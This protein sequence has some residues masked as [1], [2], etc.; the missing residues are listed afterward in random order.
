MPI[1]S[2]PG[3]PISWPR[4]GRQYRVKDGDD[5][6]RV[7]RR[8]KVD[9]RALIRH[10]FG[11]THPPTVNWYLREY[12]GCNKATRDGNNWMFSSSARPG[13]V[14]IPTPGGSGGGLEI[15]QATDHTS[16]LQFRADCTVVGAKFRGL[17]GIGLL[18]GSVYM[19]VVQQGADPEVWR[20][21]IRGGVQLGEFINPKDIPGSIREV[22]ESLRKAMKKKK[23]KKRKKP[24]A[25]RY[26]TR[27]S[28]PFCYNA[29]RFDPVESI[30]GY[31]K[32]EG[33]I[34]PDLFIGGNAFGL[35]WKWG[36]V[37]LTGSTDA[38]LMSQCERFADGKSCQTV[39]TARHLDIGMELINETDADL[40]IGLFPV[41]P[42]MTSFQKVR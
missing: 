21:R 37:I 24:S 4:S 3:K 7:A 2:A 22:I 36:V 42:R 41:H 15:L 14:Y 20:F 11:T 25:D 16:Y 19:R 8:H 38:T 23:K 31:L 26:A 40:N 32:R 6:Y 9:V 1:E 30:R 5:W 10:N 18:S 29:E 33:S 28:H 17:L 35:L 13:I 12:V 39:R 34:S 27:W